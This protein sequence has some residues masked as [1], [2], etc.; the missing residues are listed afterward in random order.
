MK[1]MKIFAKEYFVEL[2]NK[3]IMTKKK[4]DQIKAILETPLYLKN[5]SKHDVTFGWFNI[6][7]ENIPAARNSLAGLEEEI[8]VGLLNS[9]EATLFTNKP[10]KKI[11]LWD[12]EE[13][14][15]NKLF[16]DPNVICYWGEI[17]EKTG[18]EGWIYA[19]GEK[20]PEPEEKYMGGKFKA[21]INLET[22]LELVKDCGS[23]NYAAHVLTE[24]YGSFWITQNQ[25]IPLHLQNL[26][27]A[28]LEGQIFD[29]W[30]DGS[31][32]VV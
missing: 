3:V 9:P 10:I 11:N 28:I 25:G 8:A 22:F 17:N 5:V 29:G 12:D 27:L 7:Y 32:V 16:C 2:E 31:R 23:I 24:H 19:S 30:I 1:V 15:M 26:D 20:A 21:P 4:Y 6:T 14:Q 13:T 18:A